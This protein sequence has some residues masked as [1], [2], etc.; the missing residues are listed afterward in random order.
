[1][2]DAFIRAA[3][4]DVPKEADHSEEIRKLVTQ[5][6]VSKLPAK[7]KA[8]YDDKELSDWL[9]TDHN[10]Y[11]GISVSYPSRERTWGDAKPKLT[12]TVKDKVEALA[13]KKEENEKVRNELEKKLKNVAYSCTTRKQ[14]AEALPE[15]EKYLPEDEARA[16][17]SLPV[18][19]NVV[20]DFVKAGWPTK[21]ATKK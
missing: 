8:V 5:D 7:V 4:H 16:I 9:K 21:K 3:M 13:K 15:F 10:T 6:L 12:P 18:V 2:R 14:L 11:G 1:M 17:R 19:T 20:A